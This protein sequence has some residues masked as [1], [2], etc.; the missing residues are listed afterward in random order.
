MIIAQRKKI[1]HFLIF[2]VKKT[3]EG[4]NLHISIFSKAKVDIFQFSF[5]NKKEP[6]HDQVDSDYPK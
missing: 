6:S 5:R 2:H 1:N 4:L 3:D